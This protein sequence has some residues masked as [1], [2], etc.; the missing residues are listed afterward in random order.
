MRLG[1][2]ESHRHETL[3]LVRG[4]QLLGVYQDIEMLRS[5]L[6]RRGASQT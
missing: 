3:L 4:K 2:G 5:K 1:A 6:Y